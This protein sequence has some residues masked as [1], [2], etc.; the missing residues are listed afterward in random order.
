LLEKTLQEE[1][2]TDRK[3]TE[4]A[5]QINIEAKAQ[6]EEEEEEADE[7]SPRKAR[8]AGA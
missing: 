4:L 3:L 2:E 7:E 8:R 1:K 6:G 5:E